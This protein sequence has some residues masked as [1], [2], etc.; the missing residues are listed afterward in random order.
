LKVVV[1][2]LVKEI[3]DL[4]LAK[5]Y[6]MSLLLIAPYGLVGMMLEKVSF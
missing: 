6:L 4:Q 5:V 1:E 3:L 2:I